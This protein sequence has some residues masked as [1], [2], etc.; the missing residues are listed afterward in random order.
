MKSLHSSG[1]RP[2]PGI[3]KLAPET[4][5]SGTSLLVGE[6]C[7]HPVSAK[8]AFEGRRE[9]RRNSATGYLDC[10]RGGM[11]H[12]SVRERGLGLPVRPLGSA[13]EFWCSFGFHRPILEDCVRPLR[14]LGDR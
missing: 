3:S 14:R 6:P 2:S 11:R 1:E 7:R 9:V 5:G 13:F 12:V 10:A 8:C 4:T